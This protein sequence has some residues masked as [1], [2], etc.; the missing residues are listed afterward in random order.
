MALSTHFFFF[1]F[2]LFFSFFFIFSFVIR[3]ERAERRWNRD[4]AWEGKPC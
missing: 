3:M 2:L 1:R 4:F